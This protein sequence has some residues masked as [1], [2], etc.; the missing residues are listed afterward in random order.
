VIGVRKSFQKSV[1]FGAAPAWF[2]ASLLALALIALWQGPARSQARN[3]I[4]PD[5]WQGDV[6]RPKP[7][8]QGLAK[9]RFIT[10]SDYPPFHYV[11]E[12]GALTGFNVD[13]AQAICETLEVECEVKDV[14]WAEIYVRLDNGEADAAIASIRISAESLGKADFSS[15]YYATPA[16]FIAQKTNELKEISP[17]TLEGKKIGVAKNTGHEAYLKQF[18][19]NIALATF[20]TTEDAQRA[21]KDGAIDFVFGD[22]IGMT[23]WLNGVTSEGCCEF[24]GGPYLDTK[25]FGEGVGIAVKKGNRQLAQILTYALEQVH[26]SGRYEELFLRYFPISFL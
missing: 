24:R 22:G 9:L 5:A 12:V 6:L 19:P 14:D 21:L 4:V 3:D 10:D 18:F 2:A 16:R 13:L 23:F 20:D 8:M 11:D 7:D 17:E 26:A 15:R 25:F 1:G